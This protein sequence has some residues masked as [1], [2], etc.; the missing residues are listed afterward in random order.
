MQKAMSLFDL[1]AGSCTL[2]R[3]L[4]GKIYEKYAPKA[5]AREIADLNDELPGDLGAPKPNG[6]ASMTADEALAFTGN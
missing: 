6:H 2:Y 5:A 1:R 4:E 3:G